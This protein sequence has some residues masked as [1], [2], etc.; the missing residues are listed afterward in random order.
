MGIN[1]MMNGTMNGIN[2]LEGSVHGDITG[3]MSDTEGMSEIDREHDVFQF[4]LNENDLQKELPQ[5]PPNQ[6]YDDDDID[7]AKN[8][9]VFKDGISEDT[10]SE[11][12]LY[13]QPDPTPFG[14]SPEAVPPELPDAK[15]L[16]YVG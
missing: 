6:I 7:D 15:S 14:G 2:E 1:G 16:I 3:N 13:N 11:S 10:Q 8:N 12:G 5:S 4:E 9:I